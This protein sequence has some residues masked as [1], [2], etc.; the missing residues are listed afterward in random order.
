MKFDLSL[1]SAATLHATEKKERRKESTFVSI[2]WAISD[3]FGALRAGIQQC[4]S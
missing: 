1:V 3:S 4:Q 2:T